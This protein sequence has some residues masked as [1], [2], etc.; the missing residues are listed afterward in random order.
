M[1]GEGFLL[2]EFIILV[3]YFACAL[4]S[5]TFLLIIAVFL[6]ERQGVLR[7]LAVLQTFLLSSIPYILMLKNRPG[8]TCDAAAVRLLEELALHVLRYHCA[9]RPAVGYLGVFIDSVVMYFQGVFRNRKVRVTNCS[10]WG[11]TRCARDSNA[12]WIAILIGNDGPRLLSLFETIG[13]QV[14]SVS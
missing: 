7:L 10:S 4:L 14:L 6:H 8:L 1:A 13:S 5:Y 11:L 9:V 12:S 2:D 3:I